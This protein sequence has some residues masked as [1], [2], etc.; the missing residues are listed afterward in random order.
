MS[1]SNIQSVATPQATIQS[2]RKVWSKIVDVALSA[3]NI[4]KDAFATCK[5]AFVAFKAKVTG[6][7][8]PAHSQ[9]PS[10]APVSSIRDAA[11]KIIQ[12]SFREHRSR[13]AKPVKSEKV[14]SAPSVPVTAAVA[15]ENTVNQSV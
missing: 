4:I 9:Q 8:R 13:V 5:D 14:E 6:L 2:N 11:A 3:L 15:P 7:L 10:E 1:V 12:K